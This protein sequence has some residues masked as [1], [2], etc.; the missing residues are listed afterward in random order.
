MQYQNLH[1]ESE[2][3]ISEEFHFDLQRLSACL[4]HV[5]KLGMIY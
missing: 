3:E 1:L 2:F 4:N 5:G